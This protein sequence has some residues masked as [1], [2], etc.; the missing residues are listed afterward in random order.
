L[1]QAKAEG[2]PVLIDFTANWCQA[3][4]ELKHYTFTDPAVVRESERFVRLVLDATFEDDPKIQEALKRHAVVGLPTVIFIDSQ[5][6]ERR[7]LRL[8]GFERAPQ[9]LKRMQAVE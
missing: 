8:T 9:F 5:G 1:E 4:G 6:N 2:K 7:D 3:C